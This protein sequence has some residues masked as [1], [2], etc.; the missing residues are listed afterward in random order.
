MEETM[1]QE[2][3]LLESDDKLTKVESKSHSA[4]LF[5]VSLT[6]LI[7]MFIATFGLYQVYWFYKQWQA[8]KNYYDL[9]AW[10]IA[11]SFFSIFYTHS[12][13]VYISEYIKEDNR[14]YRWNS[15]A[16]ATFYVVLLV[17]GGILNQI[18]T[19][20]ISLV[21]AS[22]FIPLAVLYPLYQAQKAVNFALESV[23]YPD[24]SRLTWL[25]WIWICLFCFYWAMIIYALTLLV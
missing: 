4:P 15:S 5:H 14:E 21:V 22:I 7:I 19:L 20:P 18:E 3:S 23:E 2:S 12:L 13:F 17:V 24:N 1:S 10:P 9:D 6:K 25:N 16:M 11:R 8:L